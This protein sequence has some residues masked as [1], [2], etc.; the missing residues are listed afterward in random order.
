[1]SL[2]QKQNEYV[3]FYVLCQYYCA[4]SNCLCVALI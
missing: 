3:Q 2:K 4:C 1:M